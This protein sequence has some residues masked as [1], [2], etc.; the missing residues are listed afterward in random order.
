MKSGAAGA[1]RLS[2]PRTPGDVSVESEL[3]LAHESDS[4]ERD[5]M[6]LLCLQRGSNS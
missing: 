4:P 6:L 2:S 3:L 1:A 5:N